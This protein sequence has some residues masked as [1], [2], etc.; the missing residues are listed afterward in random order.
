MN[1]LQQLI[2]RIRAGDP[3]AATEYFRDYEP[4]VRRVI[5]ARLRIPG[6]R[7]VADSSDICQ[8]VLA[9]FLVGSAVGRYSVDDSSAMK[10]F[11]AAIAKRRAIDL[12]RKPELRKPSVPVVGPGVKGVDPV[13]QGT[14]PSVQLEFRELIEKADRLMTK[15][16]KAIAEMRKDGLTWEQIGQ[17]LGKTSDAVRKAYDRAFERIM[18][19]LGLEGPIDD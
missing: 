2:K 9:S 5:R 12:T 4:H 10:K 11:L 18:R 17:R 16:E 8:L 14:S 19:E 15:N 3:D 6:A 7:R 1:R 13:D